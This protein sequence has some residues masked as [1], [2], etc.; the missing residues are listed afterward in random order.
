MEVG[1]P[2]EGQFG[3]WLGRRGGKDDELNFGNV[4]IEEPVEFPVHLQHT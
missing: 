4:E 2:E 1:K 3:C